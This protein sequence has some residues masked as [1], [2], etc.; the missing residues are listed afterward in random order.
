MLL[1][2]AGANNVGADLRKARFSALMAVL[3]TASFDLSTYALQFRTSHTMAG[4]DGFLV[5]LWGFTGILAIMACL[6]V[7]RLAWSNK[8]VR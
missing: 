1:G 4:A 7:V 5:F 3:G 8:Q 2:L 6:N